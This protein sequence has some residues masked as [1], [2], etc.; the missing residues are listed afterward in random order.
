MAGRGDRATSDVPLSRRTFQDRAGQRAASF[1]RAFDAPHPRDRVSPVPLV[2]P[3][4]RRGAPAAERAPPA[5]EAPRPAPSPPLTPSHPP[6]HTLCRNRSSNHTNTKTNNTTPN[7]TQP[8]PKTPHPNLVTYT[9]PLH[10]IQ[11]A[12][13]HEYPPRHHTLIYLNTSQSLTN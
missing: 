8:T 5:S 11:T 13:T 2:A 7:P 3:A 10:I 12:T 9:H 4:A 6:D 1:P